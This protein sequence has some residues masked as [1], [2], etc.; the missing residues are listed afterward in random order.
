MT[1]DPS[2]Y[3]QLFPAAVS[4][5]SAALLHIFF[6]TASLSIVRSR[7]GKLSEWIEDGAVGAVRARTILESAE[8]YLLCTQLGRLCA[9]LGAG[10]SLACL[11]GRIARIGLLQGEAGFSWYGLVIGFA[12]AIVFILT[13]IVC[14]QIAKTVS[15]QFPEKVLCV[16]GLPLQVMYA[17]VG[18]VVVFIHSTVVKVLDTF[19]IHPTSERDLSISADDLSEIAKVSSE[20][21]SMEES[22]Q[23]LIEG[24]VDF[25]EGI[26]KE[27]MTPRKDIVWAKE[28]VSTAE[29][30]SLCN[31]EGVSRVLICGGDLDDVRGMILAKDL[32]QFI[33]QEVSGDAWRALIRPTY[34]VPNT[35]PLD[36]LL[37]EMRSKG[38]HLA[39]V[40][41]EH[42]GV[43][44]IVTVE[45]IVEQ[46][47]GDIFDETDGTAERESIVFE[48]GGVWRVDGG[49]SIDQLPEV[50][51][52][53]PSEGHY[54]TIAGYLLSQVGR[55][56]EQGETF[57][58][59][60]LQFTISEIQGHRIV[61]L[62]VKCPPSK[63]EEFSADETPRVANAGSRSSQK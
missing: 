13:T 11:T 7:L 57:L 54:D 56:P 32:L 21:G 12:I 33:N 18:P 22:E 9:S 41:D 35:K 5:V 48:S 52:I 30:I 17:L 51:G 39:V 14:V 27:V 10:F 61:R 60:G 36:D 63:E 1:T 8:Q 23:Q 53:E 47:V 50:F 34:V 44:G 55:L 43:G 15:L 3:V 29:L 45:D 16:V 37:S 31:R 19:Q 24:I 58:I 46:I 20:T 25:T 49:V 59:K 6:I 26:A 28:S 4:L 2:N 38:T 40:L 62:R 42:G